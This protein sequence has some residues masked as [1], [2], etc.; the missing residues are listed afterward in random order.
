MLYGKDNI[1]EGSRFGMDQYKV[2][3]AAEACTVC[4]SPVAAVMA[5]GVALQH[6]AWPCQAAGLGM[7]RPAP[8][9]ASRRILPS[10]QWGHCMPGAPPTRAACPGLICWRMPAFAASQQCDWAGARRACRKTWW[11]RSW[12]RWTA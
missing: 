1:P 3:A 10:W 5:V 8:G 7:P 9:A 12:A 2:R 4:Q 6:P 11:M